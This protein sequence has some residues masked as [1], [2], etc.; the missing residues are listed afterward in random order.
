MVSTGR[1]DGA[2]KSLNRVG[3]ELSCRAEERVTPEQLPVTAKGMVSRRRW[4]GA[5]GE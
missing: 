1:W 3:A 2:G 5:G 4:D